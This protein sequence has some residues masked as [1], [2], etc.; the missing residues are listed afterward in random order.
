[1]DGFDYTQEI[2]HGRLIAIME[3]LKKYGR[4]TVL[5][6]S[7][8]LNVSQATIRRDLKELQKQGVIRRTHGGA[9]LNG[10][11]TTFEYQY[12]DKVAMM[13]DEKERIAIQAALEIEDGDAVFLDS[14]TTTYQ[15]AQHLQERKNLTV[16]TYDM[17][18]AIALNNHPSAQ[19]IV[20]G[21]AVRSN[22]NVLVGSITEQF[23]RNMMVDKVFLSADAVD[24]NFGISNAN[25]IESGVK[26]L[27]VKAGKKIILVADR[28]KFNKLAVSK[29]CDIK[30]IDLIITD[31]DISP[32]IVE[33]MMRNHVEVKRV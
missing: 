12:H 28:T 8:Y 25:Y 5:D 31:K 19:V 33:V 1:M 17:S 6:M 21:G 15:I 2:I 29:F 23:I 27:L 13:M 22:Y 30:D 7:E 10:I 3:Y 4:L 14:G 24:R 18:I 20:T 32:D 9:V 16:I 11:S 26:S